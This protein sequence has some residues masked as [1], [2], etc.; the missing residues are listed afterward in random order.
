MALESDYEVLAG[1]CGIWLSAPNLLSIAPPGRQETE[2]LWYALIDQEC[3]V[4]VTALIESD[5]RLVVE[6]YS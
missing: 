5:E 3:R 6:H 1:E 2:N 4:R